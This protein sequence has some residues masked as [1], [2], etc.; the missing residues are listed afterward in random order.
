VMGGET[1]PL[2]KVS[3]LDYTGSQSI[4]KWHK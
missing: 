1:S 2:W 3:D 4:D